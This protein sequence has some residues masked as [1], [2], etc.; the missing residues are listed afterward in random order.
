MNAIRRNPG[1]APFCLVVGLKFTE[2]GTFA[3]EQ[4]A[5]IARRI[6]DSTLHLVH[7]GEEAA[8]EAKANELIDHLRLYVDE[9]VH[10]LGGLGG[11]HVSIHLCTG[12]PA[13]ELAALANEF[14][15]DLLVVGTATGHLRHWY[16]TST[17]GQIV[18]LAACPVLVAG[19]KPREAAV[20]D[21]QIEAAC[22]DCLRARAASN[23]ATLWCARH[24]SHGLRP[25]TY[26]YSRA[27]PLRNHDS[28]V[29]P[30]GI[31]MS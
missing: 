13:R 23:G 11:V 1:A 19:P 20:R 4:A 14:G 29:I 31:D 5:R 8:S 30:T 16:G 21:V 22:P 27:L 3:F 28:E 7:V 24:Q 6:P 9:K 17:V 15:A 26:S 25:H 10:S 18:P 2:A 12:D